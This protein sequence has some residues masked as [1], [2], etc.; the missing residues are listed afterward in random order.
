MAP[1]WDQTLCTPIFRD[2]NMDTSTVR[3]LSAHWNTL[4]RVTFS[5]A[6]ND[7]SLTKFVAQESRELDKLTQVLNFYN[8]QLEIGRSPRWPYLVSSCQNSPR[9]YKRVYTIFL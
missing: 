3:V 5:Q 1:L 4:I 6:H 8:G 7:S 2:I 9:F